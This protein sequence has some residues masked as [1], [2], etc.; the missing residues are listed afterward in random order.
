MAMRICLEEEYV[1]ETL[2]KCKKNDL[3]IVDIYDIDPK[4]VKAAVARGVHVYA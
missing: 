3:A 2:D 1:L 4:D